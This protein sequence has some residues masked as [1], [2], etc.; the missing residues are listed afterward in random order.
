MKAAASLDTGIFERFAEDRM[1]VLQFF[2]V[3]ARFEYALK[4]SGFL[5]GNES[6]VEPDWDRFAD[7]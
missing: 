2:L 4:R 6:K 7:P 3:F 5:R 1:L